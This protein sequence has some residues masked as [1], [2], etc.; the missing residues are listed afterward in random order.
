LRIRGRLR[1]ISESARNND[2]ADSRMLAKLGQ[3][4]PDLLSPMQHR[5]ERVQFDLSIIKAHH[6]AVLTR[7]R[8][9]TAIRGVCQIGRGPTRSLFYRGVLKESAPRLSP[10]LLESTQPPLRIIEQLT[11]EIH[12]YDKLI[13][14]KAE[15]EY[16]ATAPIL[17]IPG[18]EPPRALTFVLLPNNDPILEVP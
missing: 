5:S 2:K 1:P 10:A 12:R 9:V 4:A 13:E 8:L 15:E 17:T 3:A 14:R 18:V 16:P 6:A 7:A 11:L